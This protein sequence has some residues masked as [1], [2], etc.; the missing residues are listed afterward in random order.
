MRKSVKLGSSF[1]IL[2]M[3]LC[4]CNS[5]TNENIKEVQTEELIKVGD[6]EFTQENLVRYAEN[7]EKQVK[8][9]QTAE[10]PELVEIVINGET[11]EFDA[12]GLAEYITELINEKTD[13]ENE[14]KDTQ[15][16]L[17]KEQNKEEEPKEKEEE[18]VKDIEYATYEDLAR[19]PDKNKG[20]PVKFQGEIIQVVEGDLFNKY[21]F[22]V[23]DDYD[24]IILLE[25]P[26]FKLE[27]RILEGDL[28]TI[29]GVS[30]GNITYE[31]VLGASVTVPS[32]LIT[33]FT[34]EN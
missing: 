9:L 20:K 29:T 11:K 33:E 13:L 16:K 4:G 22:V 31:T 5:T 15:E 18:I 21:R 12:Q 27:E 17:E 34:F 14:L 7:L 25:I 2:T 1:L 23:G 6:K 3:L 19:N 8:H 10:R 32:V 24:Q 28:L 30:Q 26:N